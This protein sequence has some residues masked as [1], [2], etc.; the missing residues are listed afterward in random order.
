[1]ANLRNIF[2]KKLFY[3]AVILCILQG[4]AYGLSFYKPAT[5][6]DNIIIIAMPKSGSEYLSSSLENSLHYKQAKI[7]QGTIPEDQIILEKIKLFF[8]KPNMLTKHHINPSGF[9][10][11]TIKHYTNKLVLHI[12]D[13]RAVLL[14]W[15]HYQNDI[16]RADNRELLDRVFPKPP[17]AYYTL[18]L[19]EQIDWNIEHFLPGMINWLSAWLEIIKH[20]STAKDGLQILLTTYDE[21]IA[22]E[23]FLY[24]KILDFYTLNKSKFTYHTAQKN[25]HNNFRHGSAQE[26]RD[27]YT[28]EQ[29]LRAAKAMP[30]SLM[31]Y[32]DDTR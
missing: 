3:V 15:V 17:D 28:A 31:R 16:Y 7:A 20:E 5:T 22:D 12:R 25:R 10:I 4:Q 29:K 1:M 18:N 24:H 21:L 2:I 11:Q 9:N 19:Q 6:Y 27:V 26:W 14:S 30:R 8:S 23:T 32:F 13:P